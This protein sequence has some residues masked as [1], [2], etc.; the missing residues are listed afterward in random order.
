MVT[1]TITIA[2][3]GSTIARS[4]AAGTPNFRILV[5][6]AGGNLT[7]RLEAPAAWPIVSL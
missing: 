3:N 2:G 5:V 6:G 4:S 1:S 7:L